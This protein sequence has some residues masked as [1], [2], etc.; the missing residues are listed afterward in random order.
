MHY[1]TICCSVQYEP[2]AVNALD[3]L[4]TRLA[5]KNSAQVSALR[6]VPLV[7]QRLLA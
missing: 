2:C 5:A 3:R 4:S 1:A 7:L 6:D